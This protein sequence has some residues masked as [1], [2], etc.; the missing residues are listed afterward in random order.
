MLVLMSHFHDC[1]IEGLEHLAD[2][3]RKTIMFSH[4]GYGGPNRSAILMPHHHD[5][6]DLERR[7]GEFQTADGCG[8]QTVPS[9]TDDEQLSQ[10]AP[11][12]KFGSDPGI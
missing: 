8:A 6:R 5:E 4:N 3:G 1:W 12:K 10:P 9:V 7:D 2:V 11:E